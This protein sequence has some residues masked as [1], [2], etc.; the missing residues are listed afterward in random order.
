MHAILGCDTTSGIC[1][2]G[3]KAALK[4]TSTSAPLRGYAQV[5]NNPQ[6]SKADLISVGEDA[7][8]ALYKGRPG[9]KPDPLRLRKFHQKVIDSKSVVDPKVL[10]P[11]SVTY[12]S[13]RVYLEA[14]MAKVDINSQA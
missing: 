1:G 4:L 2:I 10:P 13:L 11:V 8:V 12:H 14:G 3:K 5:F 9:D 6:A 7:L